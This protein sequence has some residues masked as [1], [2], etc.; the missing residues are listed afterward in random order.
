[1]QDGVIFVAAYMEAYSRSTSVSE[2]F[3]HR[4]WQIR[5]TNALWAYHKASDK[6][7]VV[8]TFQSEFNWLGERQ[9]SA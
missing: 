5:I 6:A 9:S 4:Q 2:S 3:E 1:M 7:E 8:R